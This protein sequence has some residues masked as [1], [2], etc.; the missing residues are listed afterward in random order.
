MHIEKELQIIKEN[1]VDVISEG[2]LLKKLEKS[3]S[4]GKGLRVKYGADPSAADIHLGHTVPLQKLRQLQDLG[5]RVIFLIGDFTALIGD[6]SGVSKT[7]PPLTKRE[8]EKNAATYQEQIFRILDGELTE[9][10]FN[11]RW[12]DDMNLSEVIKLASHYTVARML[13][14]DDFALRFRKK[15]PIS[16]HEFLY[17]LIQGYDSVFLKADI[18][19]GGTDQR[20]NFLVARELQRDFGQE[21]EVLILLPL[22][23]GTDGK[24]KMS[25]S[26]DNYIGIS[27]PP[28]EIY[29]KIMSIPDEILPRYYSLLLQT[30][31]PNDCGPHEAKKHLALEITSIHH[32]EEK[33]G[34]SEQ[35]FEK[36]FVRKELPEDIPEVVLRREELKDG[37]IWI[38]ELL[39]KAKLAATRNEAR[40]L[41]AQGGVK[42]DDKQCTDPELNIELKDNTVLK[43]GK[44]HFARIRMGG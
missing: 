20:F 33:A 35:E 24:Q 25:K 7:R 37:K 27:E 41:I 15:E 29:G 9:V 39:V 1:A 6:P 44:R 23:E 17:P 38:V 12:C 4:E 13:E 2:E 14:R 34:K 3:R 19:I 16:I 18:E 43:T 8:V 22:L 10:V 30:D 21:P 26:L 28:F 32:G 36:V 42:L 31:M 11:S 5:H 40:R